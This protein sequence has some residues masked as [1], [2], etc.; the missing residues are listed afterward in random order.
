VLLIAMPARSPMTSRHH[1]IF[2]PP[3]F[4]LVV[5]GRS[6][7]LFLWLRCFGCAT[8]PASGG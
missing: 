1:F 4:V 7:R 6:R 2:V 5:A 8:L 3:A